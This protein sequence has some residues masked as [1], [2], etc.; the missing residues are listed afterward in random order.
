[1][2]DKVFY[3]SDADISR[4][5]YLHTRKKYTQFKGGLA[6]CLA[7][8]AGIAYDLYNM[9]LWMEYG[10]SMGNII[11]H[12]AIA[13]ALVALLAV[14]A[15]YMLSGGKAD[16]IKKK[17]EAV[18][19]YKDHILIL[20]RMDKGKFSLEKKSIYYCDITGMEYEPDKQR[21]HIKADCETIKTGRKDTEEALFEKNGANT[22]IYARYQDYEKMLEDIE[23]LSLKKITSRNILY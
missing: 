2:P 12:V 6:L 9:Y 16:L 4:D 5:L 23:R 22:Y 10:C 1:M 15:V 19:V 13:V 7:A 18:E 8:L 17:T 11:L 3:R 20:C 14:S 21:L